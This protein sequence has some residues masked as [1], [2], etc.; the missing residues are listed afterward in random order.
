[1]LGSEAGEG[2]GLRGPLLSS[3][4]PLPSCPLFSLESGD[5]IWDMETLVAQRGG[6]DPLGV[7]RFSCLFLL[8]VLKAV[9]HA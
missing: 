9:L 6:C 8:L 4:L 3:F 2:G 1:M 7:P 5:E